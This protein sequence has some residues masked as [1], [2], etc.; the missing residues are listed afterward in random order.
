VFELY[1]ATAVSANESLSLLK[2]KL[3]TTFY[4]RWSPVRSYPIWLLSLLVDLYFVRPNVVAMT[5]SDPTGLVGN[6][7]NKGSDIPDD[8]NR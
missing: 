5:K 6:G 4:E 2:A 1:L 7:R 3:T 8:S